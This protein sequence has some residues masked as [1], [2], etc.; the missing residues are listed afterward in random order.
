MEYVAKTILTPYDLG[1]CE[2]FPIACFNWGGDYTPRSYGC[3]GHLEHKGLII[4]LVS[5]E[6]EPLHGYYRHNHPVYLD[7]SLCTYLRFGDTMNY[8]GFEM[9]ANGALYASYGPNRHDRITFSDLLLQRF[10]ST[11]GITPNYWY[12]ILYLPYEGLAEIQDM[13]ILGPQDVFHCNFGKQKSSSP[14]EHYASWNPIRTKEP[15]FHTPEFF[16]KVTIV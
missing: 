13:P 15:D 16:G 4:K 10:H 9:N 6:K 5:E 3:M 7:S 2:P 11:S 12:V 14:M 1:D 8:F